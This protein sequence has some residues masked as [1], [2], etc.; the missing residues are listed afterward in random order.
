MKAKLHHLRKSPGNI[1]AD[2]IHIEWAKLSTLFL[3]LKQMQQEAGVA[4]PNAP[5]IS[6][7]EISDAWDDLAFDPVLP[8]A[9]TT[10]ISFV[11]EPVSFQPSRNPKHDIG[12]AP[13]E[14]QIIALFFNGNI[15]ANY[16]NLELSHHISSAEDQLDQ[17]QNLI[18][19]KSFQFSHVICISPCKRVT[20]RARST[21]KKLNNQ[22]AEHCRFYARC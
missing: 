20:M 2:S 21:V 1:D 22:I 11:P 17:I 12:P 6:S 7:S 14:D 10:P 15:S 3:Q 5:I 13:I 16:R 9:N 8:D 18:A 19:E 4:E